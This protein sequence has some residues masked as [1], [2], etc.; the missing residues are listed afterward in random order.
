MATKQKRGFA[1]MPEEKQ[2]SIAHKGGEARK[3]QLGGS[4]GYSQLGREG[5]KSKSR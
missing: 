1:S 5:G 3:R 2:R 4:K